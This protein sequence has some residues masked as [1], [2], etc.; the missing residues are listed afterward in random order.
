MHPSGRVS[1][2]TH[3]I[4]AER[5]PNT[6]PAIKVEKLKPIT[7]GTK[8]AQTVPANATGSTLYGKDRVFP[9]DAASAQPIARSSPKEEIYYQRLNLAH[10]NSRT[11][12][13]RCV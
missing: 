5:S 7:P 6:P 2:L 9:A 1:Q 3:I 10:T 4:I 8:R 11:Q 12:S 13:A